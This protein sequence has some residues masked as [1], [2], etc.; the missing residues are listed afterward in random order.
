MG[1]LFVPP[2]G[3]FVCRNTGVCLLINHRRPFLALSS[4]PS[5]VSIGSGTSRYSDI[6]QT[7]VGPNVCSGA[8]SKDDCPQLISNRFGLSEPRKSNLP[9]SASGGVPAV[10]GG[11][12]GVAALALSS[13]IITVDA[14]TQRS[15]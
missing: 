12:G 6:S 8:W 13:C 11:G 5:M 10:G 1:D 14:S 4:H 9:T 15:M 7:P 2:L 3:A